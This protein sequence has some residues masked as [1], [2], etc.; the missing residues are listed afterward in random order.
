[1]KHL[2]LCECR[3]NPAS[4]RVGRGEAGVGSLSFQLDPPHLK[5]RRDSLQP[6]LSQKG[7]RSA[8]SIN[9]LTKGRR[10]VCV[11]SNAPALFFMITLYSL[12]K[13]NQLQTLECLEMK[14][15]GNEPSACYHITLHYSLSC[16]NTQPKL[17][18]PSKTGK[19]KI[20]Y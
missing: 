5:S 13:D 2:P 14:K 3:P 7:A 18:L 6:I 15:E 19:L 16:R 4:P 20:N 1:M 12:I 17:T 11:S 8:I 9:S 10:K